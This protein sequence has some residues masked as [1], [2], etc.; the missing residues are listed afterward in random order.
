[1][2]QSLMFPVAF[3]TFSVI[4]ET[5]GRKAKCDENGVEASHRA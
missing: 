5:Q 1:M 2:D 4:E 3:P